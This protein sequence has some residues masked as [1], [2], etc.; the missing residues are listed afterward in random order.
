ML[1]PL[2]AEHKHQQ[3]HQHQHQQGR[4]PLATH[5]WHVKAPPV[6]LPD[7]MTVTKGSPPSLTVPHELTSMV[8]PL[9]AALAVNLQREA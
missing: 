3:K 2:Q 1:C 5:P 9:S 6:G 4:H 7:D 8:P